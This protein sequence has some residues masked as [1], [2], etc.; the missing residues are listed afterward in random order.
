M[1]LPLNSAVLFLFCFSLGTPLAFSAPSS[2]DERVIVQCTLA[3]IKSDGL[4]LPSRETGFIS[5]EG[6]IAFKAS[7]DQILKFSNKL[8]AQGYTTS[9]AA[10]T[11]GKKWGLRSPKT[12]PQLHFYQKDDGILRVHV[13]YLNPGNGADLVKGSNHLRVDLEGWST[14]HNFL[15]LLYYLSKANVDC[16]LSAADQQAV[17]ESLLKAIG[18]NSKTKQPCPYS[19]ALIKYSSVLQPG[20][21]SSPEEAQAYLLSN[22]G[23]TTQSVRVQTV[24]L[25]GESQSV[26]AK[27]PLKGNASSADAEERAEA[28]KALS[29]MH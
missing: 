19:D 13:D 4:A 7:N 26:F 10:D 28:E 5:K 17:S 29:K 21:L 1:R 11:G 22:L 16:G 27:E 24:R 3:K 15:N 20:P 9:Y 18:E 8:R 2:L 6:D 14:N 25:L 23:K 12:G